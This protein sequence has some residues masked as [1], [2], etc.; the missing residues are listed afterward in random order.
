MHDP[1]IRF[2]PRRAV[3]MLGYAADTLRGAALT[4]GPARRRLTGP[5]AIW[6]GLVFVAGLVFMA[7]SVRNTVRVPEN[8]IN[9]VDV[10]WSLLLVAWSLSQYVRPAGRVTRLISAS[11]CPAGMVY[12]IG[13]AVQAPGDWANYF[14]MAWFF[15][16]VLWLVRPGG[17]TVKRH[18]GTPAR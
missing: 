12:F 8:W 9:Y 3:R 5:W 11:Y 1:E 2:A 18:P 15:L 10:A 17:A 16:P 7:W 13:Q 14:F 6:L 4:P